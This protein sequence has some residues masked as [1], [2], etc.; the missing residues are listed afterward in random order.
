MNQEFRQ[1]LDS[2]ANRRPGY[3]VKK[4]GDKTYT[5]MFTQ[6]DRRS[7]RCADA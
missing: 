6:P 7:D 4:V 1:V 3:I 5:R 2:L